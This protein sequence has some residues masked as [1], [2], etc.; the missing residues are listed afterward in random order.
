MDNSEYA[1]PNLQ[2]RAWVPLL[3]YCL[4]I[5]SWKLQQPFVAVSLW[6]LRPNLFFS[7]IQKSF[8]EWLLPCSCYL[9]LRLL[10]CFIGN[11][12]K[13]CTMPGTA[14]IFPELFLEC[15]MFT[16]WCWSRTNSFFFFFNLEVSK[17]ISSS[18]WFGLLHQ[19]FYVVSFILYIF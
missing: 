2:R 14:L 7:I 8:S 17:L 16:S 18:L 11:R 13:L 19:T 4:T 15:L 3:C 1:N 6:K 9:C 5:D 12:A 10:L